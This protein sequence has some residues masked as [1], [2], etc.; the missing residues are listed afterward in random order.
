MKFAYYPGCSLKGTG[1]AYEKSLLNLFKALDIELIEIPDWNCCGATFYMSIN[2]EKGLFMTARNLSIAQNMGLDIVAPCSACYLNLLKAVNAIEEGDEVGR[3]I[4]KALEYANIS[5][6]PTYIPE[7]R[8]P[9]EILVDTYGVKKLVKKQVVSLDHLNIVPYYGCLIVRPYTRFDHHTYPTKM[10]FLFESLGT[11]V[12][13]DYPLKTRC[14]GGTLTGTIEEIG[15]ELNYLL[16]KEAIRRG[17][18]VIA[19]ICPLCH[20]NLE[21]FQDKIERA[22]GKRY[23]IPI[24]YFTH[25][26][27]KAIGLTDHEIG[28][29]NLLYK[30]LWG[31]TKREVV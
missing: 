6:D 28:I 23:G 16:L 31:E 22:Y 11:R 21:M 29:D 24:L 10:D 12:I 17:G 5:F 27:G 1:R 13:S 20:F 15:L 9:L 26:V 30:P 19:T 2:E 14:C 3:K 8:H 25:I 7:I 18:N 4:L